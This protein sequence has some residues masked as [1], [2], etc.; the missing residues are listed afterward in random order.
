MRKAAAAAAVGLSVHEPKLSWMAP[1]IFAAHASLHKICEKIC[2]G[3][4]QAAYAN[5]LLQQQLELEH[6]RR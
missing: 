1:E 5:C 4:W 2:G 3:S 6:R